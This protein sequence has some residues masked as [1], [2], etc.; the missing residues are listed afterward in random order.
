VFFS[1]NGGVTW[2]GSS[3]PGTVMIRPIFKTSGNYDLAV[4]DLEQFSD[5]LV[6][7]NP[8]TSIVHLQFDDPS[9]YSGA[10]VRS[11][12]GQV[13][14]ELSASEMEFDMSNLPAG[15]YF[16]EALNNPKVVKVI[17]Q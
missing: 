7:P 14:A 10:I 11:V 8:A 5:W 9:K 17:R 12:S 15:M 4:E 6:Y 1:L 16:V 13:I 2:T 3:I